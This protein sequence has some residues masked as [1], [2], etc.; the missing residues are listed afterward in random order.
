MVR[1]RVRVKGYVRQP[2]RRSD[3]AHV[4]M[5][6]VRR[7]TKLVQD[8]GSPGR[9][10]K[11]KRWFDSSSGVRLGEGY[12]KFSAKKRHGILQREDRKKNVSS[13]N[14]WND[15]HGKAN[16]ITNRKAK[17]VFKTDAKWAMRHL[18]NS[19]ERRAMTAPARVSR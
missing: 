17:K 2:F 16:V 13:R 14:V 15:L 4:R 7:H 6:R 10:P 1:L 9:T 5:A 3:G 12:T 18:M 11:S 8:R 19:Q